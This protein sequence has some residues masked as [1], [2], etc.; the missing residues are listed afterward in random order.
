MSLSSMPEA[1]LTVAKQCLL[2]WLGVALAARNEP[3]VQILV[4]ELAPEDVAGRGTVIGSGRRA[5]FDDA[6]LINGAM[7]HALDFDD[8]IMPMGHPT[9][10]VAPVVLVA[11]RAAR[12]DGR[13]GAHGLHRRRREPSAASRAWSGLPTTPGAG[14]PPPRPGPSARRR[15]RAAARRGGR[16]ADP[17]LRPRR[18][19]GGGPEEL[20]R[21]HVEAAASGQGGRERP[22]RGPAR[23]PRVHQRPRHPEARRKGSPTPSRR[24]PIRTPRWKDRA[25]PWVVEALFKYHAACYLTHDSIEAAEPLRARRAAIVRTPSKR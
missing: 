10:P 20:L 5:R 7:G 8:V 14:M 4:D 18:D 12:R 13:R 15:G 17:R 9:V 1:A 22:A 19:S 25:R 3:L 21:D 16:G 2:D 11:G 23:R 24:R 6:V